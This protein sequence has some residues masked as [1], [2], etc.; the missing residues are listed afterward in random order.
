MRFFYKQISELNVSFKQQEKIVIFQYYYQHV[1][2]LNKLMLS[3]E[4][5]EYHP[6]NTLLY[7]KKILSLYF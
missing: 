5:A 3:L 6:M 4:K 2:V 1:V 7:W